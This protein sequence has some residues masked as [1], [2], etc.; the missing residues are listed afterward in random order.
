M[1]KLLLLYIFW[2][3]RKNSY[4]VC[5]PFFHINLRFGQKQILQISA[6]GP[7]WEAW[8]LGLGALSSTCWLWWWAILDLGCLWPRLVVMYIYIYISQG[9]KK[10]AFMNRFDPCH[11]C[12]L[13]IFLLLRTTIKGLKSW[14]QTN[15]GKTCFDRSEC[16]TR[17]PAAFAG[18]VSCYWCFLGTKDARCASLAMEV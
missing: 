4:D 5:T 15:N 8:G 11:S 7:W 3:L 18:A 9:D 16:E 2:Y 14:T 6:R 1:K 10:R 13:L 17:G 12:L